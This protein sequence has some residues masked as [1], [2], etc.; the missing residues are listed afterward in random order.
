M[1][2]L[3]YSVKSVGGGRDPGDAV[4]CAAA[5]PYTNGLNVCVIGQ[6]RVLWLGCH[7]LW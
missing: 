6:K 3:S 7:L 2:P 4:R 1:G 5:E